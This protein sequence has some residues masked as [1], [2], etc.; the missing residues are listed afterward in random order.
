MPKRY[1]VATAVPAVDVVGDR[2]LRGKYKVI[3]LEN[4]LKELG[5]PV[6][7]TLFISCVG[8]LD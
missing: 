3:V 8:D 7:N 6:E 4:I 2:H 5:K 1:S